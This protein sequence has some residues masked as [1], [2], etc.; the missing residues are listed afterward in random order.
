[1]FAMRAC[2]SSIMVGKTLTMKQ[3][4]R[5]VR[6]MGELDKPWNCPHGRP[7]MRHLFSMSGWNGWSEGEGLAQSDEDE[8]SID[9]EGYVEKARDS[10]LLEEKEVENE[11]MEE[12]PKQWLFTQKKADVDV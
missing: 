8:E 10:G 7:T 2:R 1:M 6:H 9:W 11:V 5:V 4:E 12:D 3:M